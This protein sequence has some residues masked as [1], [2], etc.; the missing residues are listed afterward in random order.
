[1][2]KIIRFG[3][4]F[5]YGRIVRHLPIYVLKAFKILLEYVAF[6]S[7]TLDGVSIGHFKSLLAYGV[8]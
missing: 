1:M 3:A 5:R 2:A 7:A 6:L 4:G 8:A